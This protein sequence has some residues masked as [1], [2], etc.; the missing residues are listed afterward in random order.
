MSSRTH[1]LLASSTGFSKRT[2]HAYDSAGHDY[3]VY[4]DG[5]ETAPFAFT[6]K[7]SFADRE[8]WRR[9]DA[10]LKRLFA[11]GRRSLSVLDAG[12]GPGTWLRR[13]A[14][15]ARE[16]G[17]DRVNAFG[18]DISPVMITLAKATSSQ[19]DDRAIRISYAI[20]DITDGPAFG[21]EEFDICLCLYGVLNHLPASTHSRVAAELSR[22]TKD[23]LFVTVRA[24]GSQPTIYVDSLDQAREF[25]QDNQ[26]DKMEIDML[27]GAHIS[28]TSHLFTSD[29]LQALFSPHLAG[30]ALV[31]IDVFHSRFASDKRWNPAMGDEQDVFELD[32]I[33]LEHR[34]ASDPH[35]I[36]R[37]AHI[38]LIGER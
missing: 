30:S 10:T 28:F 38:L 4:A 35:F 37:A 36:N 12:C 31:G 2:A 7:Y 3:L 24:A 33:E 14:L 1:H 27:N 22:V 25:F 8:I 26:T 20:R 9:L 21:N 16:I 5:D 34:Y 13:L 23:S 15:R 6:G 29:E 11:E 32:L 17:F 19:I 18:F